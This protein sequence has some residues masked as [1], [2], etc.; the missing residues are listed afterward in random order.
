M[1][2]FPYTTVPGKIKDV[3]AK[4]RDVGVPPKVHVRWLKSVGFT[5]SN[6]ATLIGVLKYVGLIDSGGPSSGPST[7]G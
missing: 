4:I 6:D 5:S 1:A 2:D 3:L 7:E